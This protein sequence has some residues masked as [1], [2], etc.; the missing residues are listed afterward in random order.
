[1]IFWPFL[2]CQKPIVSA[3][4]SS[5]P[6]T[7][8]SLLSSS[9]APVSLVISSATLLCFLQ[10]DSIGYVTSGLNSFDSQS[11]SLNG[12][13]IPSTVSVTSFRQSSTRVGLT[14]VQ[15]IPA[16]PEAEPVGV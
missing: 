4:L 9:V 15:S 14:L 7:S 2:F 16:V 10:P 12:V 3:P 13:E 11:S 8:T 6:Q 1:M 5:N